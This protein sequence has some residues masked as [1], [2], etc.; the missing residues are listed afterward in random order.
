MTSSSTAKTLLVRQEI[1]RIN[2]STIQSLDFLHRSII[3][4]L[5]D[6][7]EVVIVNEEMKE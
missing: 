3:E 4:V 5:A 6:Q 7:G 2:K 1:P